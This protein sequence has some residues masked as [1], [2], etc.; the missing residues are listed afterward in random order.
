MQRQLEQAKAQVVDLD[1]HNA[2]LKGRLASAA[3][4]DAEAFE[5]STQLKRDLTNARGENF[6]LRAQ[7]ADLS[8]QL[9][10]SRLDTMDATAAVRD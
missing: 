1:G 10:R 7:L 4:S 5:A 9:R 2:E 8:E 3:G 6:E